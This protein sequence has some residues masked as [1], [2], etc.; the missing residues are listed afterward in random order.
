MNL[1]DFST[2]HERKYLICDNISNGKALIRKYNRKDII[3]SN[4]SVTTI[5]DIAKEILI[6]KL[7]KDKISYLKFIDSSEKEIIVSNLLNENEY[8]FI[9]FDSYCDTT[10]KEIINII[11]A[12]RSGKKLKELDYNDKI[13]SIN[14]LIIDY[15]NY[16]TNNNYYDEI[17]TIKD[18]INIIKES[19][20]KTKYRYGILE[21]YNLNLTYDEKTFID[22]LNVKDIIDYKIDNKCNNRIFVKS[23]GAFNEVDYILDDIVNKKLNMAD[24]LI[25]VSS[26]EYITTLSSALENR[27]LP[28]KINVSYGIMD[29]NLTLLLLD[30]I[31][32]AANN[33]LYSDFIK[34]INNPLI[35]L[36]KTYI[37]LNKDGKTYKDTTYKLGV[38][39]GIL[40][41]LDR[42]KL[43]IDKIENDKINYLKL[44]YDYENPILAKLDLKEIEDSIN[45]NLILYKDFIKSL[46]NIFQNKPKKPGD[47]LDSIL[48]INVKGKKLIEILNEINMTNDNN[49]ITSVL[50]L[51]KALKLGTNSKNFNV[52]L[53]ELEAKLLNLTTKDDED[54][55]KILVKGINNTFI[56]ER[57]N[58][59]FIGLSFDSFV[60]KVVESPILADDEIKNLLDNNYYLPLASE[61][62]I[63]KNNA[64]LNTIDTIDLDASITFTRPFY[65]TRDLRMTP[66]APIYNQL[67]GNNIE[68]SVDKYLHLSNYDMKY[69][70][71][72][73]QDYSSLK[74]GKDIELEFV[75]VGKM[76]EYFIYELKPEYRLTPSQVESLSGC[77]LK[78]LYDREYFDNDIEIDYSKWLPANKLGDLY[79]NTLEEYCKKYLVKVK[80]SD[81]PS[82]YDKE[83]F[84]NIFNRIVNEFIIMYP[85]PSQKLIDIVVD[86]AKINLD[87][88]LKE[89]YKDLKTNNYMIYGCEV[90]LEEFYKDNYK[91]INILD[92]FITFDLEGN[93]IPNDSKCNKLNVYFKPTSR[94]DRIDINLDTNQIRIIDYKSGSKFDKSKL[95]SKVQWLIYSYYLGNV[96][97]FVYEFVRKDEKFLIEKPLESYQ[98]MVKK[99]GNNL[100]DLFVN[101]NVTCACFTEEDNNFTC[102]YCSYKDICAGKLGLI[103][104]DGKEG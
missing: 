87:N 62:P 41:S 25:V 64:L 97:K 91:D 48:N 66:Q 99:L 73:N 76:D 102:K 81:L 96:D 93:M 24:I 7:A 58:V 34:I 94:I 74:E 22:L 13:K 46:V 30:I 16:L 55:N 8:K 33:Y 56:V 82:D 21:Y 71:S 50:E 90:S 67:L 104:E 2:S 19:N 75:N 72:F 4:L 68:I 12:I 86:E 78:Y 31:H 45:N 14:Q 98:D 103:K 49:S 47:I 83:G 100:V 84:A 5:F 70:E 35:D 38:S 3:F 59:Y 17:R 40:Y 15:E 18:A 65:N 92:K 29:D 37:E 52:A 79:H 51:N 9:H 95:Y 88:Y 85:S 101:R 10:T 61:K 44:I 63:Y 20:Y 69:N 1:I 42:Y 77:R 43:F 32:F 54:F 60:P 39:A 26:K 6:S 57:K 89:L 53:K 36:N 27:K 80:P 28:Y 23:Y 11:D